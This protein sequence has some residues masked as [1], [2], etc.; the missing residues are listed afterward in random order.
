MRGM[1]RRSTTV[2]LPF[3]FGHAWRLFASPTGCCA[4]KRLNCRNCLRR[5]G[6]RPACRSAPRPQAK[7]PVQ[8]AVQGCPCACGVPPHFSRVR[9][10]SAAKGRGHG[11]CGKGAGQVVK[12]GYAL[13]I[14]D[15]PLPLFSFAGAGPHGA[16]CGPQACREGLWW[17][18]RWSSRSRPVHGRSACW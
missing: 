12:A 13:P 4:A 7:G 15:C 2:H 14:A 11:A 18:P 8:P 6:R 5:L 1:L 3:I 16:C 10:I 9:H 17:R